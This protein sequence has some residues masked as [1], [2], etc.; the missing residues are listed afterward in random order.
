MGNAIGREAPADLIPSALKSSSDGLSSLDARPNRS[1][2]TKKTAL[3]VIKKRENVP[4]RKPP[5]AF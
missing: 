2:G 4:V 3:K 5:L 1:S